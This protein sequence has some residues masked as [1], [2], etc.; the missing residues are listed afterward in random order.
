MWREGEYLDLW[1]VPHFLSGV[2]LALAMRYVGFDVLP[3][4]VVAF[5]LLV[6]YEMFEAL[7]KIE[8]T[9]WNRTLDVVVGLV[10]FTPTYLLSASFAAADIVPA[11]A[12]VAGIDGALSFIGWRAS[13]KAIVLETKLRA[14][15]EGQRE[16]MQERGERIKAKLHEE[17]LKWDKRGRAFKNRIIEE[18]L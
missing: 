17:R 8:E 11:F 1:S 12:L 9:R 14:E 18:K 6:G 2:A 10:S 7:A 13:Q 16:K 15:I 3:T 4:F 5:L